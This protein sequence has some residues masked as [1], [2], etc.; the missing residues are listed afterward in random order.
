LAGNAKIAY[1]EKIIMAAGIK[2]RDAR[3]LAALELN[4]LFLAGAM[5]ESVF[6]G[7]GVATAG[8]P[9]HDLNGEV[10]FYRFPLTR[11]RTQV[12]YADAAAHT[13]LGAP[14]LAV[15]CGQIWDEDAIQKLAAA[16]ARNVKHGIKYDQSRFVAYSYPKVAIQ[17]LANEKEI[18]ML[19]WGTWEIVP[20]ALRR[21]REPLK[22]G[23]FERWSLLDELPAARKRAAARA[24]EARAKA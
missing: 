2:L 23:N 5:P 10:L 20:P 4:A 1:A 15:S 11:G 14:L 19:E 24:Y 9:I 13:A 6:E 17:F 12:A 3:R 22:P 7:A 18:F 8:T 21:S 16:K